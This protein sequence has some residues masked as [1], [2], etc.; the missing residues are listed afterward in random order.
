MQARFSRPFPSE[1][2]GDTRGM[3]TLELGSEGSRGA[4]CI[5][6]VQWWSIMLGEETGCCSG[7]SK[8]MLG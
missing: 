6:A 8:G 3:A 1:R 4:R 2:S 5:A 7:A